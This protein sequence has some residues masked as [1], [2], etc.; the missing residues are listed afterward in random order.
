L[1]IAFRFLRE[2]LGGTDMAVVYGALI[3]GLFTIG[4]ALVALTAIQ[5]TFGRDMNF[6][7]EK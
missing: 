4:V 5:E 3:V 7:E 6:L 2:E 1:S